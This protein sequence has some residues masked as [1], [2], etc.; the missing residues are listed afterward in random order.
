MSKVLVITD[1]NNFDAEALK[2]T[3]ERKRLSC[4]IVHVDDSA[5]ALTKEWVAIGLL[6]DSWSKGF[7]VGRLVRGIERYDDTALVYYQPSPA[8]IRD[9]SLVHAVEFMATATDNVL[10]TQAKPL[11]KSA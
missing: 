10:G 8:E 1:N 2:V 9:L 7:A 3:Y 11:K 6:F 5:E 4:E